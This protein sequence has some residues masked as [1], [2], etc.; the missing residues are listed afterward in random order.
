MIK[1]VHSSLHILPFLCMVQ[2]FKI[3]SLTNFQVYSTVLLTTV[4]M[5]HI[6]SPEL[7][8]N[9]KFVPFDKHLI[10]PTSQALETI[11]LLF[12]SSAFLALIDE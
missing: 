12:Q 5:K 6:R 8:H 7:T 9:W 1:L 3:Y 4:T 11:I 2:R 10:S